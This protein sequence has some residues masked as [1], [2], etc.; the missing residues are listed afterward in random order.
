MTSANNNENGWL[1]ESDVG[2]NRASS[3]MQGE[4]GSMI[5]GIGS[6]HEGYREARESEGLL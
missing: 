3:D 5:D 4:E 1:K 6:A 2:R